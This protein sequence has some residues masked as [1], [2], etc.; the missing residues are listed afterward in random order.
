MFRCRTVTYLNDARVIYTCRLSF[1]TAPRRRH[2]VAPSRFCFGKMWREERE[3]KFR[4]VGGWLERFLFGHLV[5]VLS[6][7]IHTCLTEISVRYIER[8]HC[9]IIV[10]YEE[11]RMVFVICIM[12]ILCVCVRGSDSRGYGLKGVIYGILLCWYKLR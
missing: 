10:H 1:G 3:K 7:N 12:Y 6:E 2:K 11:E 4:R 5:L 9:G 8:L